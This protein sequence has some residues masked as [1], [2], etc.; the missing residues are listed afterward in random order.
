MD[1]VFHYDNYTIGMTNKGKYDGYILENGNPKYLFRYGKNGL[2]VLNSSGNER[3]ASKKLPNRLVK[4]I[5]GKMYA[6]T[7]CQHTTKEPEGEYEIDYSQGE[8]M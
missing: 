8:K 5:L 2:V 7:Q 4:I 1:K 6:G 3:P